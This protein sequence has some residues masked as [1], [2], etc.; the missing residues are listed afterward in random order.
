MVDGVEVVEVTV[1]DWVGVGV[2]LEE[3][4]EDEDVVPGA[5]FCAVSIEAVANETVTEDVFRPQ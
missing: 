1:V 3:E 4:D 5:A 2:A